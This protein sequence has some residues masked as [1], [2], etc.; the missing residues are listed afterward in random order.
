MKNLRLWL[1]LLSSLCYFATT[2]AATSQ[3]EDS[4]MIWGPWETLGTA[5]GPGEQVR[6]VSFRYGDNQNF[7][8]S[9][10]F[11][12]D[13]PDSERFYGVIHIGMD[14]RGQQCFDCI[15][16]LK[17]FYYGGNERIVSADISYSSSAINF[18]FSGDG[19]LSHS[20]NM[21]FDSTRGS[22]PFMRYRYGD[23]SQAR[24][25]SPDCARIKELG[26]GY[27]R[28][29]AQTSEIIEYFKREV[30]DEYGLSFTT[31][32][33]IAGT[34]STL[35]A[36]NN[37]QALVNDTT[38][39]YYGSLFH[40]GH[41]GMYINL[42]D[43]SWEGHFNTPI[44]HAYVDNG[45]INGADLTGSVSSYYDEGELSGT[46]EA[47]FFGSQAETIGGI[48]DTSDSKSRYVDVFKADLCD[49]CDDI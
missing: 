39:Y 44:G 1:I 10:N 36:I 48:L 2:Q 28:G 38:A 25:E 31:S 5:A 11:V 41:V 16:I 43:A 37:L 4:V 19:D 6:A 22:D 40:S 35:D 42:T 3:Q 29:F 46:V 17:G 26:D 27:F 7:T 45:T 33:F 49:P 30:E 24:C 14:Y 15:R 34:T 12:T 20:A 21:P 47:S 8:D 9:D 32:D 23:W 13:I 18:D